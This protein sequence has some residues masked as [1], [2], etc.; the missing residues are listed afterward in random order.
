MLVILEGL[1]MEHLF[2]VLLSCLLVMQRTKAAISL[3]GYDKDIF[4]D[5]HPNDTFVFEN[6]ITAAVNGSS[7]IKLTANEGKENYDWKILVGTEAIAT[8]IGKENVTGTN[9]W[10][11]SNNKPGE[12]MELN[13]HVCNDNEFPCSNGECVDMTERCNYV[14]TCPDMSDERNCMKLKLDE[15]YINVVPNVKDSN[16]PIAFY[17]KVEILDLQVV[18]LQGNEFY[19]VF[20]LTTTWSDPG[21]T[22]TNLAFDFRT[23][24]I[25]PQE[26]EKIWQPEIVFLN[27]NNLQSTASLGNDGRVIHLRNM[28]VPLQDDPSILVKDHNYKGESCKIIMTNTYALSFYYHYKI[29]DYPFSIQTC[30]MNMSISSLRP[31]FVSINPNASVKLTFTQFGQYEILTLEHSIVEERGTDVLVIEFQFKEATKFLLLNWYLPLWILILITQSTAYLDLGCMFEMSLSVNATVFIAASQF[32]S[33]IMTSLDPSSQ[34][35]SFELWIIVTFT[36][37]FIMIFVQ[38]DI[39]DIIT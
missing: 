29:Y 15:G 8:L 6:E 16:Q 14:N 5:L 35:T 30:Q 19:T 4:K 1:P 27:T 32:F 12:T 23:N 13:F 7:E 34:L 24:K 28:T 18:N 31:S 9:L 37:P 20:V 25:A 36:Y 26:W 2:H 3:R 21:I 39:I 11:M 33:S 17:F 10:N 22:L 38:V